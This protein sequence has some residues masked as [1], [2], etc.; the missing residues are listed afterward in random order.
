MIGEMLSIKKHE[1]I[2][3]ELFVFIKKNI[4]V[5]FIVQSYLCCSKNV[6]LKSTFYFPMMASNKRELQQ[7]AINCS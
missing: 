2:V 3:T 7:I 5:V 1:P 6:R 4:S